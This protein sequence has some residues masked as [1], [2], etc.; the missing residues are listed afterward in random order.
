V[1]EARFDDR[2]FKEAGAAFART[3]L[4]WEQRL[5]DEP[6]GVMLAKRPGA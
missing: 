4:G 2:K 6:E 1:L 5:L 3:I